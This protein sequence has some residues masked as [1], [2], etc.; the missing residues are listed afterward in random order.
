MLPFFSGWKLNCRLTP[1]APLWDTAKYMP[2]CHVRHIIPAHAK[3]SELFHPRYP[4]HRPACPLI[5]VHTRY[6]YGE[7]GTGS[8]D[9]STGTAFHPQN[10]ELLYPPRPSPPL[11]SLSGM[12]STPPSVF[13]RFPP[14]I[15]CVQI[16]V[17]T[18][19][20]ERMRALLLLCVFAHASVWG[21]PDEP[22]GTIPRS[23][24]VK[25]VRK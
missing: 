18:C 25:I 22:Q 17:L 21:N 13:H 14:P 5:Y 24:L 3:Q 2:L 1:L 16:E 9:T 20:R 7:I 12:P 11:P 10:L 6:G 15:L 4:C 8:Y 19:Q 23:E